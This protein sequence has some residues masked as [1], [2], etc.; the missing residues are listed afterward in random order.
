MKPDQKDG[1]LFDTWPK[2]Y[3]QWFDSPIGAWVKKYETELFLELLSPQKGEHILDVG[4]GTGVFTVDVVGHGARVTGLDMS[5][6]MLQCA[7]RKMSD[8]FD[9]F[10]GDMTALPFEDE[11]FDKVYSMTAIEFVVDAARAVHELSRVTRK[12]G[13]IVLTTLNR[14]SPWAARRT[15][16]GKAGHSLFSHI[17]FRSP[18][19]L[20]ALVHSPV[21][22]QTAI[23]FLKEDDPEKIEEIE[24]KGMKERRN[25]GAFVAMAWRKE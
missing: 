12:N 13:T 9:A 15:E 4:C 19:E 22:I 3:E 1:Q 23:H 14:L 17:Y 7:V 16:A 6:P 11:S 2:R 20:A 5:L 18:A 8:S 21:T 25:T 10:V 24:Q